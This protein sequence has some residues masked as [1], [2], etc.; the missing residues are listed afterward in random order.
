MIA[1]CPNIDCCSLSY[2]KNGR[3]FRKDDSRWIT[4][5]KCNKCGKG[6]SSAT[7]F[8]EYRQKKRRKNQLIMRLLASG[9][10]M[11]RCALITNL[12]RKT[13]ERKLRFLAEKAR[14]SQRAFLVEIQKYKLNKIQIDDL[15][16][17]EH[18]KLKPLSISVAI[19]KKSRAILSAEVSRIPAFGHLAKISRKKYGFRKSELKKGLEELFK[20][21][22]PLVLDNVEIESDEHKLYPDFIKNYFPKA[23]HT[24][25]KSVRGCV[26]GQGELKKQS[27]DPIFSVNHT[28]AMLRANINRL[29][30]RSWCTTKDP[31]RLKDHLAI[32]IAFHNQVLID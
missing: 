5:F 7:N 17:I 23:K 4:R 27:F 30:R 11:R 2:S 13:I 16:T 9:I 3:Y 19:D 28:L 15:I 8:L 29:F 21:I 32:Y 12:N 18:T 26:T 24:T 22:S 31:E 20:T 25:Y 10:S 6:F 1:G 14:L